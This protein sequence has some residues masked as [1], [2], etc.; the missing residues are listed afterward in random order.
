M[1]TFSTLPRRR[2]L[3]LAAGAHAAPAVWRTARAEGGPSL[4]ERLADYALALRY[5]DLDA[6]T[7][8]QAKSLIVDS[9]ACAIAA[10]DEQAVKICRALALAPGAGS[11][12]ILGTTHRSTPDLAAFANGAA[13]RYYDLNDAY[14]SPTNGAVHPSD[15]IGACLAV[16]EAEKA[17]AAD[18][19]AAIVLAYE[20]NCR[21]LDQLDSAKRGWDLTFFSLPA[22][23]LA[24]AKLMKLT[25]E[26]MVQAVNLALNDHIP[27]GQTRSQTNSDWKGLADAEAERNAV[28]AAQ[29]A[30]GGLTGPSPIFEGRKGVFALV[31]SPADIDVGK[32]GGRGRRFKIHETGVKVYQ[33][34]V[35][36]QTAIV[37]AVELAKKIGSPTNIGD[38]IAKLEI[39]STLRGYEQAGRDREKWTPKNRDTADHSLPYLTARALVD[40][41]ITNASY[42][43]DKLNDPKILALMQ[44]ITVVPDPAFDKSTGNAPPTRLAAT[45]SDGR[46]VTQQ[47]DNMPGF[48]GQPIDRAGM[49]RKFSDNIG[50]RWPA[51]KVETL[52]GALWNFEKTADLRGLLDQFALSS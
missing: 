20:I 38:R 12:K 6:A 35:Y 15:H 3:A 46:V 48:P 7:I 50:S 23:A 32:F 28:F 51:A 25:R 16:A 40:G 47:V 52:A 41:T 13:I 5:E 2:T 26:Q 14:A 39:A 36:S 22:V 9:F 4:A 8:E 21:L 24:S 33:A 37:A 1:S 30:R 45:L 10:F 11:A 27:M 29:L 18:A 49:T 31:S 43:S 44:K 19:L 17:S 42:A 34:V